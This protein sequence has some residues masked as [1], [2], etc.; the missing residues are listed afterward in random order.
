[1]PGADGWGWWRRMVEEGA[2]K[3]AGVLGVAEEGVPGCRGGEG[4]GA[5]RWR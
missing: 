4:R 3:S 2:M 1:M 5:C